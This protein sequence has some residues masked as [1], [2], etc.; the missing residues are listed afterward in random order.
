MRTVAGSGDTL[1]ETRSRSSPGHQRKEDDAMTSVGCDL[2][3]RDQQV[4]V[5]D[6]ATG[7]LQERRLVHEVDPVE[8]FYRSLPGPATVGVESTGYALWF[9]VLLQ[10]LEH[11]VIVGDAAKIRAM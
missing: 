7:E 2:H 5:L 6:T 9:H 10:R 4:A 3:A 8:Q 1:H 11:E